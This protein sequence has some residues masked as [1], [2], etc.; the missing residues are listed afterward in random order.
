MASKNQLTVRS[1][2]KRDN[3]VTKQAVRSMIE[4]QLEKKIIVG[5]SNLTASVA[6]SVVYYSTIAQDDTIN[7]RTGDK[8]NLKQ[9]DWTFSYSDTVLSVCRVMLFMD[10]QNQG[11]T[12]AVT[13]VLTSATVQAHLN[14]FNRLQNR[15]KVLADVVLDVAPGSRQYVT[16]RGTVK[17]N[18]PTFF[19]GTTSGV[20]SAG[21]NAL[22]L[23]IVG[24]QASG[25]VAINVAQ[26]YT[27]A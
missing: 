14:T 10:S 20:A 18:M 27:D 7:G 17:V 23:L 5:T 12:P 19:T 22:F 24:A 4:S 11:A 3:F 9:V 16:R 26:V 21:R 6:G 25:G 2:G 15:F 8:I 1:R 13:D